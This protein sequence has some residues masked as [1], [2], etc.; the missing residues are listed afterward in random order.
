MLAGWVNRRQQSV[1]E[2]LQAENCAQREQLG[3][4]RIR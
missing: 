1:I 2:Y 4:K 3:P